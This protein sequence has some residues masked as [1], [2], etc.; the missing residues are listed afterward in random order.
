MKRIL[1]SAA[2]LCVAVALTACSGEKQPAGPTSEAASPQAVHDQGLPI[3]AL[4]EP[5]TGRDQLVECPYLDTQWVADTNGQ[6]VLGSGIDERFETP[7]CVFWSYPEDP[8]LTV[9]VRTTNNVAESD[10]VVNWAAPINDTE[11]ADD[12][13]GWMGG[14]SGA[15]GRAVYAVAKDNKAVVVFTN[16]DQ[17]FKAEMVAKEVIKNLGL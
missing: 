7:A 4:P 12:P 10:A 5:P 1:T 11:P 6:R 14:R 3:D 9:I 15:P 2:L 16:Q 13:E 17:S 8:Q